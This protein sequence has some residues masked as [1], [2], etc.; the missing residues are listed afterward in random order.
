MDRLC[1]CHPA[2]AL[3]HLFYKQ[4]SRQK[5][6][7]SRALLMNR[8]GSTLLRAA[9]DLTLVKLP[10]QPAGAFLPGPREETGRAVDKEN[11]VRDALQQL[12]AKRSYFGA[13]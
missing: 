7:L 13:P 8:T 9:Y 10:S 5:W 3:A 4:R 1:K 6:M 2:K 11:K 12:T